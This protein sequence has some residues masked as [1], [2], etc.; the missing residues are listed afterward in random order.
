MRRLLLLLPAAALVGVLTLAG[1]ARAAVGIGIA[2]QKATMF[3]D[4]RFDD[5]GIRYVRI[6]VPWDGL[7]DTAALTSLDAWMAGARATGARPLVTFD[8]SR[9]RPSYNPTPA[10]MATAL[11]R[12]R[13]RYP[14]VKE[15]STWNEANLAK[16]PELVARWY[17]AMRTACPT[18][19]IL[20]TD[21]L[22]RPNMAAWA[23]RF[24]KAAGRPPKVW[25]LHNYVDANRMTTSATRALLRAVKGAVWFTETG[26]VVHRDN[27][28]GVRFPTSPAR[29]A[30]VTAFIFQRLATLSPRVQRVYL[31]HWDTGIDDGGTGQA[32]TWDSGFVGP[33]GQ[34]R[35]ALSVLQGIVARAA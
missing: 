7:G 28:S 23:K 6:T 2:D 18:C 10:Q 11:K 33:D 35:P 15:V 32:A 22:D 21:L 13:V 19:T 20:A 27:G 8:R 1:P 25:G 4:P 29:A 34:S 9:R 26:G 3:T 17:R 14:E 24:V 31:Y 30:Q 16:R 5:L 12:L